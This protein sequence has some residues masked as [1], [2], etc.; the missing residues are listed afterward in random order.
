MKKTEDTH[1]KY[2]YKGKEVPSCTTIVGL[3]GKKELV[4]WANYMGFKRINT[5][6][7]LEEKA[8]YGTY[9]HAQFE[10]YFRDGLMSAASNTSKISRDEYREIMYK[11]RMIELYFEKL[12]I[13][14]LAMEL[15]LEGSTYGGTL[16]MICYNRKTDSLMIFDL[17][18]SKKVYQSHWIQVM[19]YVQLVEE[20]YHLP[21]TE[22]GIILLS[23]P[24]KSPN[25]INIKDV[26]DCWRELVIFNRLRDI[27]YYMNESE[28]SIQTTLKGVTLNEEK[29]HC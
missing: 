10:C 6:E 2:Y 24:L 8:A 12:G 21:V 25:L 18:T 5:T 26:S 19:G 16:D 20:I 7:L 1:R 28:E 14:V 27:Y 4:G 17:K 11:F 13:E 29:E 9:C 22:I 15:P 23:E 3:L